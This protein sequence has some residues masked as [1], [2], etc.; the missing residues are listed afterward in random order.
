MPPNPFWSFL[1]YSRTFAY[2]HSSLSH[3]IR[4]CPSLLDYFHNFLHSAVIS[5]ISEKSLSSPTYHFNCYLIFS[6]TLQ[7]KPLDTFVLVVF[8]SSSLLN[9]LQWSFH[10]PWFHKTCSHGHFRVSLPCSSSA[11]GVQVCL[12]HQLLLSLESTLLFL[13]LPLCMLFSS[14]FQFSVL[15]ILEC[16]STQFL[17]SSL[18]LL[19]VTQNF[20]IPRKQS[21]RAINIA[22]VQMTSMWESTVN[23]RFGGPTIFLIYSLICQPGIWNLTCSQLSLT[24]PPKFLSVFPVSENGSC[25]FS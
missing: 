8:I 23:S 7:S 13:L 22:Y 21:L 5:S 20:Y 25:V 3:I 15:L 6:P 24:F 19:S 4:D 12:A 10:P 9:S 11:L 18:F 2:P 16:L 17:V 1:V 14:L